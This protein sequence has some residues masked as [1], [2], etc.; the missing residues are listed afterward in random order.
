MSAALLRYRVMAYVVGVGLLILVLVGV[1]L[2]YAAGSPGVVAVV[3]PIH[4][5]LYIVYL[6]TAYDLARRG[7][8]TLAQMAEVVGAGFVP[9]L[10]FVVERQVTRRVERELR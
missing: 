3:G 9:F 10:A 6:V 7:R 8:W 2:K 1:P 4:G 5:I